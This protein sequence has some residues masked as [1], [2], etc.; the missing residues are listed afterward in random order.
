MLRSPAERV[1]N[2]VG[3]SWRA[4]RRRWRRFEWFPGP[5][6]SFV[7]AACALGV[8]LHEA[9]ETRLQHRLAVRP[10][11]SISFY[12]TAKGTGWANFNFGLGPART[13]WFEVSVDG[14]PR[15]NWGEVEDAL[16]L[17]RDTL[18]EFSVDYPGGF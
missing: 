1:G 8:S 9:C 18:A 17:S 13:R 15:R 12:S 14:V 3:E 6:A 16:G 7:I 10:H 4:V 2:A 11:I 5:W